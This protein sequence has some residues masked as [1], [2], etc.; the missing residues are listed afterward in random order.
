MTRIALAQMCSGI[1]PVAN[2]ASLE[3]AIAEA[4]RGGAA[5]LFT[6]EMSGLVDGNRDRASKVWKRES[7][8]VVVARVRQAAKD[9]G[10]W[11]ALG[12][13]AVLRDNG[14]RL[15]NRA[16]VIDA[17]GDVRARYEKIH[18]FDVDLATGESWR[19][20]ATYAP[21]ETVVVVDT[22]V[23][24][25]GP[26]IC[27]DVRF[28]ALFN[29]MSAAGANVIGAPAA[30]TVP[31]GQAHWHVLHRARA[32]ENACFMVSAA[33][34]GQHEDGRVTYGHSL[35]IDPWGEVLLD[36]GTGNGVGFAD[37]S[38]ADVDAV[39]QRVPVIAHRRPIPEVTRLT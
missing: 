25:Y 33:Q 22:P 6:P 39:R 32:I 1:D 12:S 31:T 29:A 35:V 14:D 19:E 8:D 11:V 36:M 28:P 20:S 27:Y 13:V 37:I 7:E 9:H 26:S 24:A 17:N 21:G 16:L 38:I 30:F 4:A 2:A 10:I 5:M 18:L 34:C 15:A 23:G 3:S